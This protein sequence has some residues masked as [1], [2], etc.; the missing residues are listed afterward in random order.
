MGVYYEGRV[1]TETAQEYRE[2]PRNRMG[3]GGQMRQETRLSTTEQKDNTHHKPP[4]LLDFFLECEVDSNVRPLVKST[5]AWGKMHN[6]LL[7]FCFISSAQS[8][9]HFKN[10]YSTV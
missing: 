2:I 5:T 6:S 4:R 3:G 8:F 1:E 9:A 10:L 7:T